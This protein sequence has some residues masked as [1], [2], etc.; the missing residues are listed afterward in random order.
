MNLAERFRA[1]REAAG[2][3]QEELATKIGVVQQTINKIETGV[4]RN[5]RKLALIESLLGLPTGYLMYG[6]NAH[7][8]TSLLPQPIMARCPII[9]W[10]K[11]I[12][13]PAN[14]TQVLMDSKNEA[15][16]QKIVL[17]ANCYALRINN[18]AM[19]DSSRKQSFNEGS[20]IIVDPDVKFKSGSLVVA[21]ENSKSMLFRRYVR[22]GAREYLFAYNN[23][24]DPVKLD[25]SLKIAGVVI[26]HLDLLV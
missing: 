17:G 25:E 8:E 15:L 9:S 19:T 16:A 6:E 21:V 1:A 22:E 5:P 18:D 2:Y 20:Y 14:R 4:I 7:A 11:A 3:S 24:Y 12:D 10:E 13:W 26:A 23:N